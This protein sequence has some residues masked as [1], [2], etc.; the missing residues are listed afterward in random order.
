MATELQVRVRF[1]V[2]PHFLRISR[3][4]TGSLSSVSTTEELLERKR[5]GSG[6]ESRKY[7]RRHQSG[8]PRGTRYPQTL[9]LNSVTSGCRSVGRVCW[10][11]QATEFSFFNCLHCR[12]F[13]RNMWQYRG[14]SRKNVKKFIYWIT[15]IIT[16]LLSLI[17]CHIHQST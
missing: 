11:T 1:P 13:Y 12:R 6:L 5:S 16:Y 10:R 4:G 9:E 3:S 17:T 14:L 8:W 2:L 7:G 15:W